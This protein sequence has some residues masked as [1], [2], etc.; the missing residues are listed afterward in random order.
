MIRH[1]VVL[2]ALKPRQS[3]AL[4]VLQLMLC[5]LTAG[6]PPAVPKGVGGP[7]SLILAPR[8]VGRAAG[9]PSTK[10]TFTLTQRQMVAS[11]KQLV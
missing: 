9:S 4:P 5:A 7:H 2:M 1:E 6:Q 10:G 11:E 3:T 8:A